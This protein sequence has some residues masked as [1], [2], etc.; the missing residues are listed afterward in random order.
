MIYFW[1][2]YLVFSTMSSQH[3]IYSKVLMSMTLTYYVRGRLIASNSIFCDFSFPSKFYMIFL[4]FFFFH[5]I[6][7]WWWWWW[8]EGLLLNPKNIIFCTLSGDV[9]YFQLKIETIFVNFLIIDFDVYFRV[10]SFQIFFLFF[11]LFLERN[12]LVQHCR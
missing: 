8:R 11:F 9:S 5:W 2:I 4:L 6:R 3:S 1:K 7:R 10:C 12:N